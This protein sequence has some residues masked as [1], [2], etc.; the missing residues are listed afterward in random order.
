MKKL[1]V[2]SLL[3]SLLLSGICQ[4][5]FDNDLVAWWKLNDNAATDVVV[6]SIGSNTGT[7]SANT[8]TKS[9]VGVVNRALIFDA[10]DDEVNCGSDS[11]IDDIFDGGATVSLWL[12]SSG[13]G[14]NNEGIAIGKLGWT[15]GMIDDTT[16]IQFTQGFSLNV[17]SW[18]ITIT[19]G[20]WQHLIVVYDSRSSNNNPIAYLNGVLVAATETSEPDGNTPEDASEALVIGDNRVSDRSWDGKIDNVMLFT[21]ELTAKEVKYLYHGGKGREVIGQRNP[22]GRYS[23]NPRT[24]QNIH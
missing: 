16:T 17:G 19:A 20:V 22:R 12:L 5:R 7:A 18:Q 9:V 15:L 24:R 6:D 1:I 11:S 13:R 23:G 4:A 10:A 2:L 3:A 14:Q 21:R 8:D